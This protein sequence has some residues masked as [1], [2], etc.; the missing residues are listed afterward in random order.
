MIETLLR[1]GGWGNEMEP[2]VDLGERF[3]QSDC[4]GKMG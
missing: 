1:R 3:V 4:R 2:H